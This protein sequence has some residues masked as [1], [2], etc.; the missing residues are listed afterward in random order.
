[1]YSVVPRELLIKYLYTVV[2]RELLYFILFL[3][4]RN[5]SILLMPSPQMSINKPIL[6]RI[7]HSLM[8]MQ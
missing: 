5:Q 7:A 8:T 6:Q 3:I 4:E 1:M 2:P